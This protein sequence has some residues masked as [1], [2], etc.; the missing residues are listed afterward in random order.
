MAMALRAPRAQ[1]HPVPIAPSK[2]VVTAEG[3][4]WHAFQLLHWSF[5]VVPIVA[6]IDKFFDLLATWSQYLAPVIPDL[7]GVSTRAV[8]RPVGALEI[9]AGLLVAFKPS[10]GGW[11]VAAWL[12]AIAGNLFLMGSFY[13]VAL[14]DIAL[15]LG[16]IA[17]ARLGVIYEDVGL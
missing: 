16:A 12:W 9:I 1:P 5:V 10:A 11:V 6:G 15:S 13:D 4:A 8:M 2:P 17:M 14:R 3:P 7:L